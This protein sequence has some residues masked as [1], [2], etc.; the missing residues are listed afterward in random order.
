MRQLASE[1]S[2]HLKAKC[3]FLV[4]YQLGSFVLLILSGIIAEAYSK[5]YIIFIAMIIFMVLSCIAVYKI[6][7]NSSCPECGNNFFYKGDN[8]VN[9]G[10]LLYTHKCTNCGYKLKSGE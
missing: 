3:Y 5:D 1:K 2:A 4:V 7:I 10:F 9:L 6:Y 8:P